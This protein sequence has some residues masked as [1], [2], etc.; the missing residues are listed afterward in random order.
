MSDNKSGM[1]LEIDMYNESLGK[2]QKISK[3]KL[4][5]MYKWQCDARVGLYKTIEAID[6]YLLHFT[7]AITKNPD[8]VSDLHKLLAAT[9]IIARWYDQKAGE[10][11]IRV[12][13]SFQAADA[14]DADA[15]AAGRV[16]RG[17]DAD[18]PALGVGGFAPECAIDTAAPQKCLPQDEERSRPP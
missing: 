7:D 1:G 2:E 6:L 5:L 11:L 13:E 8:A 12:F 16:D 14:V 4:K 9:R 3:E 17:V 15:A 18:E 10:N